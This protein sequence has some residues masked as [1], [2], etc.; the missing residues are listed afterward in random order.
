M[1]YFHDSISLA[2]FRLHTR[3]SKGEFQHIESMRIFV[4]EKVLSHMSWR[5]DYKN[6]T[7]C[8]LHNSKQI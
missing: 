7:F 2:L 1:R 8:L 5:M 6:H 3:S 4:N